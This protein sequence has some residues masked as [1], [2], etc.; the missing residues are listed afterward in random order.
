[1]NLFNDGCRGIADP[2]KAI[3]P[4]AM[5]SNCLVSIFTPNICLSCANPS[6]QP[7]YDSIKERQPMPWPNDP[8]SKTYDDLGADKKSKSA[9]VPDEQYGSPGGR[10]LP[11][12]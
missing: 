10:H 4:T 5:P 2:A 7:A 12:F 9:A 3:V 8:A 6:S 1:M 11:I